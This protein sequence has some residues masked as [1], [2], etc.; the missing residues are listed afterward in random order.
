MTPLHERIAAAPASWGICELPGWGYQFPVERVLSDMRELGVRA[1]EL[2]PDGFVPGTPA[3]QAG[4]LESYGLAALG[5]FCPLILHE[6]A[7]AMEEEVRATLDMFQA[8][9]ANLM[10]I[11]VATGSDT[12]D[13]RPE[14]SERQWQHLIGN[15]ARTAELAASRGVTACVHPH[16]GTLI[17][18]PQEVERVLSSCDVP[19]CLDS[20][21]LTVG[22]ADVVELAA[23]VP[24][25]IA[26]VHLKDVNTALA[27]E[28]QNGTM[29]YSEAVRRGMYT[30]LGAGDVDLAKIVHSLESVGYSGWYVPELDQMLPGVPESGHEPIEGIRTSMEYLRSLE[31]KAAA[32]TPGDR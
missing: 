20:G 27:A 31:S 5:A 4:L 15:L 2:G 10:V 9:G 21:H 22:G 16:M 12:Y 23:A 7:G 11:A 13:R 32:G 3:A 14:L 25:R 24:E 28:V 29:D 6:A 19:L 30:T 1:T 18:N 17:Q 8:L 26:H